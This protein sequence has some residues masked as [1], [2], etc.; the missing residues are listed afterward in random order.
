[1]SRAAPV[2]TRFPVYNNGQRALR[3]V[4]PDLLVGDAIQPDH[5]LFGLVWINPQRMSGEPCF[6]GTRVPLQTLFHCLEAGQSLDEFLADFAGVERDQT[7]ALLDLASR[8]LLD[9]L[10]QP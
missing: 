5:P 4:D 7:I 9:R 2:E 1:M 3:A 10:L 6:F 8:G